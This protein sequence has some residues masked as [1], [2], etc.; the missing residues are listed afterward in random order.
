MCRAKWNK[1]QYYSPRSI[2]LPE[3]R[4]CLSTKSFPS[5]IYGTWE[6]FLL[7]YTSI[8]PMTVH[9]AEEFTF[10]TLA[11]V[12]L[13]GGVLVD[14]SEAD[15]DLSATQRLG[16]AAGSTIQGA[17]GFAGGIEPLADA[18]DV[19]GKLLLLCMDQ[20]T[21]TLCAHRYM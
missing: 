15:R 21:S 11:A 9:V 10:F 7:L 6:S 19:A 4:K 18:L 16:L 8:P 13:V 12:S 20:F 1:K 2:L 3:S 17:G 5:A 14:Q